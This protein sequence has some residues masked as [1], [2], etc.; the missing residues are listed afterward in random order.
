MRVNNYNEDVICQG[1]SLV[2]FIS[3]L[4]SGEFEATVMNTQTSLS[5]DVGR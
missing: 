1:E 2:L 3:F 4:A 5:K